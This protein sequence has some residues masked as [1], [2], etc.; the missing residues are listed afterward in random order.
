MT[1]GKNDSQIHNHVLT[2]QLLQSHLILKISQLDPRLQHQ[3]LQ[4]PTLPQL[5]QDASH[6]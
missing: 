3:L 2:S 6:A 4:L 1:P 5:I